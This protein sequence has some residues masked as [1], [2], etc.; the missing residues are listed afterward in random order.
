MVQQPSIPAIYHTGGQLESMQMESSS[1]RQQQQQ[2]LQQPQQQQQL[3]A[4][5]GRSPIVPPTIVSLMTPAHQQPSSNGNQQ[6]LS[7][8]LLSATPVG[9]QIMQQIRK[10]TNQLTNSTQSAQLAGSSALSGG[11][12]LG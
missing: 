12:L 4:S 11:K 2:Q 6:S 5:N 8:S 3:G 1:N 9:N 7:G 10:F